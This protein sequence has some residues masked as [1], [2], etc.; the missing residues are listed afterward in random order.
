LIV[1]NRTVIDCSQLLNI[2]TKDEGKMMLFP[3]A[4]TLHFHFLGEYS[5]LDREKTRGTRDKINAT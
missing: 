4:G 2:K 1:K 3:K 5:K